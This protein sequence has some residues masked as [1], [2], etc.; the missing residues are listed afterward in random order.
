M[1]QN[2]NNQNNNQTNNQNNNPDTGVKF[3]TQDEVNRIVSERLSRDRDAR[4]AELDEREKALKA[5]ELAVMAAEKLAAAELPK[6]LA[7]VLKYDDEASLD[8]AINQLSNMKGFK[9]GKEP[10]KGEFE[11]VVIE[12]RLPRSAYDYPDRK[13]DLIREAFRLQND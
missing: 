11:P 1:E 7:N 5:R 6:E 2:A 4:K 3:F 8:A 12:N 10:G 9:D 13:T